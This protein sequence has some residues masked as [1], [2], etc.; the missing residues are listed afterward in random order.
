MVCD[1]PGCTQVNET[2]A[3]TAPDVGSPGRSN[4]RRAHRPN[5][6]DAAPAPF[7][8]GNRAPPA[9]P[10]FGPEVAGECRGDLLSTQPRPGPGRP[11]RPAV[12]CVPEQDQPQGPPGPGGQVQ[13]QMV[14]DSVRPEGVVVEAGAVPLPGRVEIRDLDDAAQVAA[15]VRVAADA[16]PVVLPARRGVDAYAPTPAAF[17]GPPAAYP[18]STVGAGCS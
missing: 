13:L 15:A 2:T 4:P 1:R 9:A 3:P 16:V 11:R 5:A 8:F 12:E 17:L 14:L 10:G 7:A 18:T 6:D